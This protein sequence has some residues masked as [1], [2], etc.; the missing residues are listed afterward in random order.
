MTKDNLYQRFE[1]KSRVARLWGLCHLRNRAH[2]CCSLLLVAFERSENS[3]CRHN[4]NL[5]TVVNI[6]PELQ[7]V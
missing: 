2:E 5:S 4:D 7:K 6:P 1:T 3:P